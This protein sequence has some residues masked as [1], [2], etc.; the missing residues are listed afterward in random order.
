MSTNPA[1]LSDTIADAEHPDSATMDAERGW[2]R[3]SAEAEGVD[4]AGIRALIEDLDSDPGMDPHALVVVRHGAVVASAQWEP[5]A[6]ERPQLVYSLSKSF[7][8]TAAGF[9][10]AE[11]LLD[12]DKPAADYFPEY[13]DNVAPA[14]RGILVRHLA[15]MATGHL[16]DMI[17]AFAIDAEHPIKAFLAAPPEREPGSVFTYNQLATYT[18]GA[19]IQRGSGM[20]LSEYLRTRLLE[21]LGIAPVGWQQEP[22]DVEL[23]FSGL[24]ATP[25]SVAKL[26]QLYLSGGVWNGRRLLPE[27]WVREA[28]SKHVDNAAPGGLTKADSDWEQGYGFQFWMARHGFRG[29]GAFGQY[30]IVLPEQDAVVAIT[31]QTVDM[32]DVLNRVWKHLLPAFRD[33]PL[34]PQPGGGD[35]LHDNR[36]SIGFDESLGSLTRLDASVAGEYRRTDDATSREEYEALAAVTLERDGDDWRVTLR[37]SDAAADAGTPESGNAEAA[38]GADGWVQAVGPRRTSGTPSGTVGGRVGDGGWVMTEG[39]DSG[40]LEVP[41][42]VRGGI[43]S[44]DGV[45]LVDVAFIDTPHRLRLAFDTDARTVSPRWITRALGFDGAYQL[46]AV[47]P[48][49]SFAVQR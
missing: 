29:D 26:G 20:R 27:S 47:R 12:L 32:Q 46:R 13:A 34:S 4:P 28:T 9:A 6:L 17:L 14:S 31:S 15:S 23:G 21:P 42:A 16:N 41:V 37:E 43:R 8:T 44:S 45:V 10:V 33:A 2:R 7:T 48:G 22:V 39:S 19:I 1:H 3:S 38:D 49:E 36:L 25:E 11:G 30:C 5:Y 24:F 18:L 40:T 35:A